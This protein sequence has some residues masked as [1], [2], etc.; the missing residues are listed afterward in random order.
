MKVRL[1]HHGGEGGLFKEAFDK[2]RI[3]SC[4]YST[5]L[6][7]EFR[8]QHWDVFSIHTNKVGY[9]TFWMAVVY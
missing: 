4:T 6:I 2:L 9:D 5:N 1:I 3:V 8:E 7:R